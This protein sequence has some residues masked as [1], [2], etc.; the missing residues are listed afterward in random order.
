[1]SKPPIQYSGPVISPDVAWEVR[2]HLQ[3]IYQKLGNH[4]QG[5]QLLTERVGAAQQPAPSGAS[6]G[7]GGS[8]GGGGAQPGV[9]F[10]LDLQGNNFAQTVIGW[11]SIPL[12]IATMG[13]PADGQIPIYD[14][15][16]MQW[17]AGSRTLDE[18]LT[19]CVNGGAVEFVFVRFA[20]GRQD[21]V[22]TRSAL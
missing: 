7:S 22:V 19:S 17:K 3:L 14:A 13:S 18:P 4:T 6:G 21:C 1:M 16:A 9:T 10:S 5:M 2:R 20:N 11:R 15:S 8:G 12:D